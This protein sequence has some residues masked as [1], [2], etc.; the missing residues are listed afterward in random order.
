MNLEER[1][2]LYAKLAV[3]TG[4]NIQEGQEVI[5]NASLDQPEFV[6]MVVREAYLLKAK[7]VIVNWKYTKVTRLMYEHETLDTLS[8]LRSFELERH[9][10]MS[11]NLPAILHIVSDDP[12]GFLG[13][14][15]NKISKARQNVYP[16]IKPYRE[17]MEDKYQWCI[18]AVPSIPWAKKVYPELSEKQAVSKLWKTILD[19]SRV[20]DDPDT[21][22]EKHNKSLSSKC[23]KLN[24]NK[25]DYLHYKTKK[26]TDFKVWLHQ[27]GLFIGGCEK[28]RGSGI[29]FN[30][31]IPSEEIFTTPIA[32]KAEGVV[33]STKPLIYNGEKIDEFTVTFKDGVVTDVT[34][35]EG[36][37]LLKT[38]I[39]SDKGARKLGEVAL[40]PITSPINLS[41]TL[42]YE[43]L[44]DEN[45]SCHLA[46]GQGFNMCIKNYEKYSQKELEEKGINDSM[47]HVDFMIG[48]ETLDIDGYTHDGRVIPIFRSGKWAI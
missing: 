1:K 33:Y 41:N 47:I 12:E 24:R 43:T 15:Q 37:N 26:G 20:K 19:C 32:G 40:V 31:N 10:W 2:A 23:R 27:D 5:I 25:F 21:Q 9:R 29:I 13:V 38:M 14:D 16:L 39:N 48:D 17:K 36:L 6:E 8:N 3:K 45:A 18:L 7:S 4:L 30:P 44:F 35:K 34:A 46:L 22:W 42:F 11:A 28:T